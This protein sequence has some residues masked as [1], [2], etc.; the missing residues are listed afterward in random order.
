M[1]KFSKLIQKQKEQQTTKKDRF[2]LEAKTNAN[3]EKVLC[4][5]GSKKSYKQ[6]CEP[7]HHDILL[8]QTPLLL[9]KSRYTAYVMGNIDYLMISHHST[10]QPISE[11]EEILNWT[12]SVKWLGLEIIEAPKTTSDEG[13]V[14]FKAHFLENGSQ[15]VIYEKSR[16]LKENNY[17]TYVDGVHFK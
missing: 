10:T 15:Q 1:S 17:W 9:M 6:C 8:A 13:F 3:R 14:T 11:K 16:F 2:N 12:K 5:C 7:I 4:A